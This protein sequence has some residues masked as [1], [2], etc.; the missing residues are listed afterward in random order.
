MTTN[1]AP[2]ATPSV[3][4]RLAGPLF[5]LA[6]LGATVYALVAVILELPPA[7][8]IIEREVRFSFDGR[9]G[10]VEAWAVT[11]FHL[12]LALFAPFA[13]GSLVMELAS[14]RD[15]P[16]LEAHVRDRR[17]AL[18]RTR[19]P[20]GV[21]VGAVLVLFYALLIVAPEWIEPFGFLG[22]LGLV[23]GPLG[24]VASPVLILD[25][26]L[27]PV[28]HRVTIVRIDPVE[29]EPTR[30][31]LNGL[32]VVDATVA[33]SLRVGSEVSIVATPM[34]SSVLSVETLDPYR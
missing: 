21:G 9:Y 27:S 4:S 33:E 22:R 5:A 10:M 25:S 2:P 8:W 17:R 28:L 6:I 26:V 32:H 29:H 30:R 16:T 11:W 3:L 13:L 34:I 18:A 14:R 19:L 7:S 23:L 12:L 15:L 1:D 31:R 24:L 20:I